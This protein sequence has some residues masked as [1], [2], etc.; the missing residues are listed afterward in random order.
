MR[1]S[2]RAFNGLSRREFIIMTSMAATGL[3]MGCATNPVTGKSQFMIMDEKQ[4]IAV[5]R[6]QAPHQFS[7]D[8]GTVQD[9]GLQNYVQTSGMRL[10]PNTHRSHMPYNFRCVN[11]TYVNAYAFPGGSIA[12]TRGILLELENE[13][14][15]AALLGHELG[16]VN[17]RHTAEIMSKARLTN[18]A[19]GGLAILT[20]VAVGSGAGNLAGQLGQLGSGALLASY[21]RDNERQ[22]DSLGMEYM[23]RS[24]YGPQGMVGLMEMLNSMNQHKAGVTDLL[25]AT[26]PMSSERYQTS[27]N[28]ATN[29]YRQYSGQP[30]YRDRYMDNT[31]GLRKIKGAIKKMQDGEEAMGK[32]QFSQAEGLFKQALD[33][34]PGDY[35]GLLLMAKCQ[36]VQKKDSEAERYA[37]RAKQVYPDEPQAYHISGI[38]KIR[39]KK[40]DA[41]YEDF[42]IYERRLPGN[43]NTVFFQGLSLEG[44]EKVEPAARAYNAYLKQVQQGKQA[45]YAYQRLKEWGYIK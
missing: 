13:A 23:A 34:A 12:C 7:S 29:D 11:A 22:A 18:M 35:V 32:E 10:T 2:T 30:L 43:P 41:A 20:S 42:S 26:H 25:F 19:V 9:G 17:A 6:Q 27:V 21:S 37:D 36:L 24:G 16:H 33:E 40:Y 44:M 28:Q 14:E 45:Q 5:D 4:E 8:Y 31:A 3:A 1:A 38:T 15:L 39:N